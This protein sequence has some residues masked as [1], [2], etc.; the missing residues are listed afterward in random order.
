MKTGVTKWHQRGFAKA[1]L[2]SAD[3]KLILTDEDGALAIC[4]ATPE[5]FEVLSRS[6]VLESVA[7]TT[8]T[9]AGT[10]LY[11]RDRKTIAAFDMGR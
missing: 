9:L 5:K 7:W 2:V 1:Q 4:R 3:G 8:P 6:S 10:H 11:L